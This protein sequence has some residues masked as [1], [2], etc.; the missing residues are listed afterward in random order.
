MSSESCPGADASRQLC[1]ECGNPLGRGH[2][3]ELDVIESARAVW[4]TVMSGFVPF[5]RIDDS[6]PAGHR[7]LEQGESVKIIGLGVRDGWPWVH[8]YRGWI[9]AHIL[10][11]GHWVRI[12]DT[13]PEQ[14]PTTCG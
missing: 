8:T 7:P 2:R 9:P 3:R 14:K 4:A 11:P 5:S 13:P 6:V 12:E 1:P 10:V